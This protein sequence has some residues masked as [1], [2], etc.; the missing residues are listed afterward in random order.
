ME[1]VQHNLPAL[2]TRFVGRERDLEQ[3]AHLL[4]E[5]R[6]LTLTGPG[7]VG[8]TRLALELAREAV[9]TRSEDYADGVWLVDLAP[10]FEP[11][12]VPSAVASVLRVP[13]VAGE[14][15]EQTLAEALVRKQLLLVIDNCE[16]VLNAAAGLADELLCRCPGLQVLAT[17]R[18]GLNVPGEVAW[19]VPSLALDTEAV[20]LFLD[21]A[22]A[23]VPNVDPGT[24]SSSTVREICRRLDGIPL[25][26]ELAA[27]RVK[28]LTVE[29]IAE[30]LDD[31][32][33]LLE[34]GMR[35]T[36]ARHQTLRAL[37]DWSYELLS[38]QERAFLRR[39]SVFVGGWT[40]EAAESVCS[41]DCIEQG[42][43]L[44][45]LANLVEKSLVVVEHRGGQN[46]YRFLETLR[47]YAAEQL[48]AAGDAEAL[49]TRHLAYFATFAERAWDELSGD[50]VTAHNDLLE[51]E[52]DNIRAGLDWSLKS[53]EI[54]L[55]LRLAGAPHGFW[56]ATDR[57]TEG[58]TWSESLLARAPAATTAPLWKAAVARAV[59][60]VG[61]M[62]CAQG[63]AA[64]ARHLLERSVDLSRQ[65]R[66]KRDTAFWLRWLGRAL[67]MDGALDEA[68]LHLQESLSLATE[69]GDRATK[70]HALHGLAMAASEEARHREVHG[71]G[72]RSARLGAGN[73]RCAGDTS[74]H[75]DSRECSHRAGQL[76]GRAR[77]ADRE[78]RQC[79]QE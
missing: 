14:S 6:L 9:D 48:D 23:A 15:M 19:L 69:L 42:A 62:A 78:P 11:R 39:L 45:L 68:R 58:R 18:E 74:R 73:Q 7:G 36:M 55:G 44:G 41:G 51:P 32:F 56:L 43:V 37:V 79:A 71:S 30:R 21:R 28:V 63:D 29:Q 8:K 60:T 4:A 65:V 35:T 64:T 27:T 24:W 61:Q 70:F 67:I 40:L 20:G 3:L 17:S 10:V 34:G 26:I 25:A 31:R 72:R 13:E 33:R 49:R 50:H 77:L 57:A 16:H 46:R 22:A 53:G 2:L 54:L 12:L 5:N 52:I 47:Q 59:G 38:D 66:M 76:Y 1:R 75:A